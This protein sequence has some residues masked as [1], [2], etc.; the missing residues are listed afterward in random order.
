[1]T[2]ASKAAAGPAIVPALLRELKAARDNAIARADD[3]HGQRGMW[4]LAHSQSRYAN[5]Q[6][7]DAPP[8]AEAAAA[9]AVATMERRDADAHKADLAHVHAWYRAAVAA[10]SNPD[11]ADADAR[12]REAEASAQT[13][14]EQVKRLTQD[15]RDRERAL[16]ELRLAARELVVKLDDLNT[17]QFL[18]HGDR[19]ERDTLRALLDK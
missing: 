19:Q 3:M 14:T 16:D 5:A 15:L 7:V 6:A 11:L 4:T 18:H 2:K 10:A 12:I 1:M 9:E 13:S 17:W 8:G